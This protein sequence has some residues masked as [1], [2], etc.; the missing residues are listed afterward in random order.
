MRDGR[1]IITLRAWTL[2]TVATVVSGTAVAVSLGTAVAAGS[3]A[4][5]ANAQAG[6]E[7]LLLTAFAVNMSNI[8]PPGAL[9]VDITIDRWSTADE[10]TRLLTTMVEKG[11]DALLSALQKMPVHGRFSIPGLTGPDPHQLRLG[12]T[13][14]YA[15]QTPQPDG[16]R[17]IIIATDR[18]I[19]FQELQASART[20]DYP[21]TLIE[22]RLNKNGEGEG[23]MAVGTMINFNRKTNTMELE[24]YASEPVRLSKVTLKTA[25]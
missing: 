10:R 25:K 15:W 5:Q 18:Y 8:G 12:H 13:L 11:G 24:N 21:F 6:A 3:G 16:G 23:K 22:I 2:G 19:G 20:L 17:R 4:G 1:T 14:H 7:R 9:V